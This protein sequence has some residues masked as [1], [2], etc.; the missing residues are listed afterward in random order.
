MQNKVKRLVEASLIFTFLT[1]F[2]SGVLLYS[3]PACGSPEVLGVQSS[4]SDENAGVISSA[5]EAVKE[6]AD[7]DVELP[8]NIWKNGPLS[9]NGPLFMSLGEVNSM[10]KEAIPFRKAT[11]FD[12]FNAQY[13]NQWTASFSKKTGKVKLLYDFRSRQYPADGPENV[14]REFLKESGTLFGMKQDLSDLKVIRVNRT[15]DR[16]HVKLQQTYNGIPIAD[17]FVLAHSNKQNQV[18]MVQNNYIEEFQPSN[19]EQLSAEAAMEI[20]RNDLRASLG[21]NAT[22]SEAKAEKLIAPYEGAYYYVWNTMISTRNPSGLWVYRVD[23]STGQ[24]LHKSNQ[25]RSLDG[26]GRVYKSNK[27][28]LSGKITTDE[29]LNKLLPLLSTNNTGYLFGAH[30]AIHSYN[31]LDPDSFVYDGDDPFAANLQFLY[32]PLT[33]HN[34]FDTVNAYYKLN[35]IWNWWNLNVV[36]K[37]VNNTNY[38]NYRRYVPHFTDNYPIPVIVNDVD[39]PCDAF[40]HPDIH[41]NLSL[42]PGFVFGGENTCSFPNEDLVLDEDIVAHEFAHFMVDQCGFTGIGDQFDDTLYGLSMN[43]GNADFFAFLRTNNTH[44][45][46][47]AW[48]LS[49]LGYLRNLDNTRIYPDDVDDPG[50]GGPEPHYTG[51]IWGG[52][53]YDL[54]KLLTTYT[55]KYVFQGFYYFDSSHS[56][57]Q[58]AAYAQYLAEKDINTSVPL[59][60]KA[61]GASASRGLS[62]AVRPCYPADGPAGTYWVF[63]PTTSISTRGNLHNAGDLH[64][65]WFEVKNP[66]MDLTVTVSSYGLAAPRITDPTISVYY[67]SRADG[68]IIIDPSTNCAIVAHLTTV[69]PRSSTTTQLSW[70]RLGAGLYS[71]VVTGTGTGNYTF[72]A[73]LLTSPVQ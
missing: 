53:L 50:L 19:R 72:N 28:Y 51:Q 49:P 69:G 71:I 26:R 58:G 9:N 21:S 35:V 2:I 15:S 38:P 60:R 56:G 6:G 20:A 37:Y 7:G 8:G 43:E 52:Y 29:I 68:D 70:P 59:S 27:N 14:A 11:G 32:D 45:G 46:N 10:A 3:S 44:M 33:N 65:Y 42:Q 34:W 39:E 1:F 55:L 48:A 16:D 36:S 18:T 63:P 31:P 4:V 67:I 13:Q 57:F 12:V 62:V 30:A 40:Y 22:F 73:S 24:I 64:E 5:S 25:I 23:A 17:V 66:V 47:V 61:T 41:G 54:Y